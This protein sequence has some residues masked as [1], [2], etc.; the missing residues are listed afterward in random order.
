MTY[1][2]E[3][4]NINIHQ[5]NFGSV[6][7]IPY[8][9]D[10]EPAQLSTEDR[11]IFTVKRGTKTYIRKTLTKADQL[12]TGEVIIT[13]EPSDTKDMY[14]CNFYEYDCLYIKDDLEPETIVCPRFFR[15]K[16]VVST[17][18]GGESGE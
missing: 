14:P 17:V 15:V 5:G 11:I 13:F 3:Y 4:G 1:V 7:L 2:D 6:K 8:D 18:D 9:A 12:D 10:D 16:K